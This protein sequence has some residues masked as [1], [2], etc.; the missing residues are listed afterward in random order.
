VCMRVCVCACACLGVCMR[1]CVRM[2]VCGCARV[3]ACVRA[4]VRAH[5]RQC[6]RPCRLRDTLDP[7]GRIVRES[8]CS[9]TP[10]YM[11]TFST[12][13]HGF[14]GVYGLCANCPQ[15]SWAP[16]LLAEGT[17]RVKSQKDPCHLGPC[18][19]AGQSGGKSGTSPP[20]PPTPP[21]PLP[22]SLTPSLLGSA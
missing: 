9:Y 19:L 4:C 18:H 14:V 3:H 22:P 12:P 1:E 8:P 21:P 2:R 7:P 15:L 6:R 17:S 5:A 16:D 10:P 20:L 13:L 11:I